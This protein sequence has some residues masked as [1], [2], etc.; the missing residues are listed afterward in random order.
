MPERPWEA[1]FIRLWEAGAKDQAIADALRIP[2]GT[3]R[4]RIYTLQKEG[5]LGTRPRSGRRTKSSEASEVPSPVQ[6]TVQSVV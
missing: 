6:P 4:S 3:V 2:E 5:K 1:E